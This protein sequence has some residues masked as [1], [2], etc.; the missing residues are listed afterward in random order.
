MLTV[1]QSRKV[2]K[3]Y[4]AAIAA[5]AAVALAAEAAVVNNTPTPLITLT[6]QLIN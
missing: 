6:T 3:F 5:V 1:T 2:C 4:Y